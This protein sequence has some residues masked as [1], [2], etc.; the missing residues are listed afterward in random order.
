MCWISNALGSNCLLM[1]TGCLGAED[2]WSLWW[3]LPLKKQPLGFE[4]CIIYSWDLGKSWILV[5]FHVENSTV[6]HQH[7]LSTVFLYVRNLVKYFNEVQFCSTC[8]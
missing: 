4:G 5:R 7:E 8:G 3:W 1:H 2:L 6:T